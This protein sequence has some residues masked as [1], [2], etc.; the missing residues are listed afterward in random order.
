MYEAMAC[1]RPMVLAVDGEA[2]DLIARQ[3]G[4][5]LHVEPENATALAQA[6]LQLRDQPSWPSN[7]GS[8]DASLSRRI[9]TGIIWWWRLEERLLALIEQRQDGPKTPVPVLRGFIG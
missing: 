1:A 2:R 8:G 6:V 5:A 7:W 3:A 4:A 9:S